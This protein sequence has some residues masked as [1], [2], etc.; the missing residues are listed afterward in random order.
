MKEITVYKCDF[1]EKTFRTKGGAAN[2]E[3]HKCWHKPESQTCFTCGLFINVAK[4]GD[5]GEYFPE[6]PECQDEHDMYRENYNGAYEITEHPRRQFECP[7]WEPREDHP[8]EYVK[9]KTGLGGFR[10]V[11]LEEQK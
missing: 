8:S 1:C 6:F 10:K 3:L 7:F 9:F 4:T 2:H 11:Y 5:L